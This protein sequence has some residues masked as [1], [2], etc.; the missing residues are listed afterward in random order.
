VFFPVDTTR[1]GIGE[2]EDDDSADLIVDRGALLNARV[3]ARTSARVHCSRRL[4]VDPRRFHFF[5][6]ET[7]STLLHASTVA[8]ETQAVVRS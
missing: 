7:G 4:A 6:P 5:D 2:T 3:D 1:I 8:D